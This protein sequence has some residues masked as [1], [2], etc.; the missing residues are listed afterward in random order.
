VAR[1][2]LAEAPLDELGRLA[3]G[4]D[5]IAF[6]EIVRRLGDML[7]RLARRLVGDAEAE[8]VIQD[9][10]MRAYAGLLAGRFR[11]GDL[12]SWMKRVVLN[13]AL[14]ALSAHTRRRARERTVAQD[15]QLTK[16][17]SFASVRL[18]ELR[19]ALEELPPRQR[20]SLLLKELEGLSAKEIGLL[21]DCSE[22]AVEQYLLRARANLR[23]KLEFD[24]GEG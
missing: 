13:A 16:P 21:L 19:D 17:G 1:V 3:A 22:G 20:A 5:E 10:L 4:G 8:D 2:E 7:I 24:H 12:Q 15:K 9:A 14:D 18:R 23:A 11:G 6:G